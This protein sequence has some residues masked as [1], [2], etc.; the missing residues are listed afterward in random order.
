MVVEPAVADSITGAQRNKYI[1][2]TARKSSQDA[3]AVAAA[4]AASKPG[5]TMVVLAQSFYR[6]SPS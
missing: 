4:I 6:N 3:L 1:F 2:R 5:A